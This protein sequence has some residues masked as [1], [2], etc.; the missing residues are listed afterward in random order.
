MNARILSVFAVVVL[1]GSL[2]AEPFRSYVDEKGDGSTQAVMIDRRGGGIMCGVKGWYHL[3]E[4]GGR[5]WKK[6]YRY[7][8]GAGR[9]FLRL[10]DG[11]LLGIVPELVDNILTNK[12]K[13]ANFYAYFSSDEGKSWSGRV[14]LSTDNRRLY[15][16]NDRIVRLSTGRIIVPFSLHPNELLDKRAETVGWVNAFY[17]DDE[18][19]TWKEG[20]RRPTT[21][22]DQMC[23]PV[24]VERKDGSLVMFART[25]MGYLYRCESTDGGESWSVEHPSTLRSPLAPFNMK[26]DP[27]TG[28]VFVAW[29]NSFPS[30]VMA[31]PRCPLSF[32]VSRDDCETWEF[33]CDIEKDPM[34]T[35]GYPSIHFTPDSI[36]VSYYESL[37]TRKYNANEQRCKIAGFDRRELTVEKVTHVPLPMPK[38]K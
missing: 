34:A 27:Y 22:A 35:Y 25:G 24:L 23:E 9:H 10:K 1:S 11:R 36:L 30:P 3:S 19:A 29:D 12:L 8:E 26:K 14:P 21:V 2:R 20:K 6:L 5:T 31:C 15:L 38:G 7:T 16:M 28:W 4:D 33:I 13:A 32:A 17:S 18:G 37:G